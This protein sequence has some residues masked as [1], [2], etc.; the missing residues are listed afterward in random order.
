MRLLNRKMKDSFIII[1]CLEKVYTNEAG[2]LGQDNKGVC[3]KKGRKAL[4]IVRRR[5]LPQTARCCHREIPCGKQGAPHKW[6]GALLILKPF[7]F[8]RLL[9]FRTFNAKTTS[10]RATLRHGINVNR[11]SEIIIQ[12]ICD[13]G[14][15][16]FRMKPSPNFD[17]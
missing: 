4:C 8:K 2:R 7:V 14:E 11:H 15:R 10:F 17:P 12:N 1:S 13:H 6:R 9:C 16:I 5:R 3:Q